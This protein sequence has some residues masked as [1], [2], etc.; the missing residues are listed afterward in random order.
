[1]HKSHAK[2][3]R[4]IKNKLMAA[5]CMLLVSSIMMVS[6]TYAW[7]TLSTAPEVTGIQTAVGA[8]GNLEM[9]LLPKDGLTSSI[10]SAAGDS[11]LAIEARNVTWGNLVDVSDNTIYGLDKITLYPSALSLTEAGKI[12]VLGSI[13][14]TP[15]YGADGRVSQ[16]A[17]NSSV[18]YFNKDTQSFSPNTEKGV[19]AVGTASGMTDRQLSYRN[20]RA[21]ANTAMSL[22]ANKASQSLNTN[23]SSLANI[24]I[25]YGMGAD[26]ASFGKADVEALRAIINDLKGNGGVLDQMETAYMQ[27]ILAIAASAKTGETDTAWSAVKG[28]V[29]AN[30]ATLSSVQAG[31]DNAG[32]S[33]PDE[34][35]NAITAYNGIVTDVDAADTALSTLETELATDASATFTWDEISSAMRPLADPAAM[36]INGFKASEVKAN[37]GALV[38][39]V[40]AQGGLKVIM[41]TNHT[42]TPATTA[43]VYA[44]IA[45][46]CGDYTAS[47]NIER[48]E[49]NGIILEN[50][51]A[52]M[53]TDSGLTPR[54]YLVAIGGL[55]GTGDFGAPV[56]GAAGTL[57]ISDMYGYIIDLAFRTNATDSKLLLQQ[58]AADRIYDNNSNEQTMGHGA[59]M[60]FMATT[61]DFSNDQVKSLMGCI[62]IVFFNP[63]DGTIY[64]YAKLDAAN[65][66][67]GVDGWTAKIQLYEITGGGTTYTPATY[68]AG[69][70]DNYYYTKTTTTEDVYTA[71][72][73][74]ATF[75]SNKTYYVKGE[76]NSYAQDTGVTADNFAEKVAAGL[77]TME[78][79]SKDT[80]NVVTDAEAKTVSDA[81]TALF[82]KTA[83]TATETVKTDNVIMPLTQNQAQAVSVL[84][85][86]D[87]NK[88]TNASVAAT[89]TS[90]MTGTMNLQFASSANLVPMEYADLHIPGANS[91]ETPSESGN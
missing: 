70:G 1:M 17:D 42:T 90:S 49:Y 51:A 21:A 55:I 27:Y 72:A 3:R 20:A 36:E 85:Y 19:R 74:G 87:G 30:G 2:R 62:R 41:K 29:E 68:E 80:Y 86:L 34:L 77:F 16:L 56:G 28:L 88:I 84:V 69:K 46:H 25:E 79:V 47:V 53:E 26:T 44:E 23:G 58:D 31:L 83:G 91:D 32:V 50:M 38:S 60:T 8:N 76:N 82:T 33:L 59:T 11:V 18:G 40:T 39:S 5:I 54:N 35:T 61:T 67:S 6:S 10:T 45:D 71:V 48:V 64:A 78:K 4:D 22:A 15:Q 57:P 24:A 75:D 13:L 12:N 73:T 63:A 65:A 14:K 89:G 9:A 81:G 43:G 52:R 66:T 7:F 37:L